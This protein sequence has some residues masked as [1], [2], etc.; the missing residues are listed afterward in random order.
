MS[1]SLTCTFIYYLLFF[2]FFFEAESWFSNL[3]FCS[4]VSIM[5][6]IRFSF[7][8]ANLQICLSIVD[9]CLFSSIYWQHCFVKLFIRPLRFLILG[10]RW[11]L[12]F[13]H[14]A[15]CSAPNICNILNASSKST[16][17]H[18]IFDQWVETFV[19]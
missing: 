8:K 11:V 10:L 12:K 9:L 15:S 18:S 13:L 1:K 4:P 19:P 14:W 17:T 6:I 5:C 16:D 2:M 7:L 3:W